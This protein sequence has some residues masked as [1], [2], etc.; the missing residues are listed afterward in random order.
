[1]NRNHK[2]GKISF[3][4]KCHN[5]SHHN[6]TSS[7]EILEMH[8]REHGAVRLL[9]HFITVNLRLFLQ[10]SAYVMNMPELLFPA[11]IS[12]RVYV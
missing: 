10:R 5:V 12:S 7:I 3:K 6:L 1:M 8:Q 11:H 2:R 9:V 4:S